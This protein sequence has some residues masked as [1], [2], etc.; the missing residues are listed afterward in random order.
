MNFFPYKNFQGSI[1]KD[2]AIGPEGSIGNKG[3]RKL[4]YPI[5]IDC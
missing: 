1:G 5:Y 4:R 2:G 3:A